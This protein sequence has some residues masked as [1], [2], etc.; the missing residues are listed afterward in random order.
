MV[1]DTTDANKLFFRDFSGNLGDWVFQK[2]EFSHTQ[3]SLSFW[4]FSWV[5]PEYT[6]LFFSTS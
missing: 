4:D 2:I 6:Y 1:I 3:I 5:S